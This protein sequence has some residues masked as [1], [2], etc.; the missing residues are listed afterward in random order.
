[1]ECNNVSNLLMEWRILYLRKCFFCMSKKMK[2]WQGFTG[3]VTTRVSS[4]G[5]FMDPSDKI[6][7]LQNL[8]REID[9]ALRT[10]SVRRKVIIIFSRHTDSVK[11]RFLLDKNCS[12]EESF[13][14]DSINP[15]SCITDIELEF[16]MSF[17]NS[18]SFST[19][20][21]SLY[22]LQLTTQTYFQYTP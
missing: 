8:C 12:K 20:L 22:L 19:L 18:R 10:R 17:F 5:Y 11:I 3:C 7:I 15:L 21:L 9:N 16:T 4:V 13:I 6:S 2:R 1:M 14:Y